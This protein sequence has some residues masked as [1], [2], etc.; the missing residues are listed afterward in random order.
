MCQARLRP[1][2]GILVAC[3]PLWRRVAALWWHIGGL[4]LQVKEL[5]NGRLAMFSMLGFFIQAIVTGKGPVSQHCLWG[6]ACQR[7]CMIVPILTRSFTLGH[8]LV[9]PVGSSART[10]NDIWCK[11]SFIS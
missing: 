9:Q 4:C 6:F 3:Q 2:N 5:K 7:D 11:V 1:S 10:S 8:A